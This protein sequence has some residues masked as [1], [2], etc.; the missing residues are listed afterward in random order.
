[1]GKGAP[2]RITSNWPFPRTYTSNIL[3]I[4]KLVIGLTPWDGWNK[5]NSLAFSGD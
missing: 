3:L 1:M 5:G 2:R 4:S